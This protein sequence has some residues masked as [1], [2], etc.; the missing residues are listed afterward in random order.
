MLKIIYNPIYQRESCV[1]FDLNGQDYTI[2]K[3]NSINDF[4]K[5]SNGVNSIEVELK[6]FHNSENQFDLTMFNP[7][8]ARFHIINGNTNLTD[9]NVF[10]ID[11]L[12]NRTKAYYSQFPFNTH[13]K[14]WYHPGPMGYIIPTHPDA[15][16]KNK[17]YVAPNKTYNG[18]RLYRIKIV[19][20]LKDHQR[21]L[22]YLGNFDDD[23]ESI[24]YP[25]SEFP[26]V[27]N[28]TDLESLAKTTPDLHVGNYSPPH[29]EY[30]KN[31]F[32]SIYGETIEYGNTIAV[33]EKTYDPLIK[34]HFILPFSTCGFIKHLRNNDFKFPN[35]INYSYD[36]IHNDTKRFAA[37]AD[38]V[39]RLLSLDLDT[40]RAH[41]ADNY[42][43]IRH[44]QI[45][46]Y[47]KPYDRIDFYKLLTMY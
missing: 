31:T 5:I 1:F 43:I 12:F 40:W 27:D 2:E 33:T 35:F 9:N 26:Q 13:T 32:I 15:G 8:P 30:Y 42:N 41:W 34:G 28:I 45:Q 6:L 22:G 20:L 23:S 24:L 16:Q 21:R 36:D 39:K 18:T 11:F 37:Y 38:E 10:F 4:I 17:I 14:K 19:A 47:E 46:F 7:D 29:N 25:H 3:S 44:N